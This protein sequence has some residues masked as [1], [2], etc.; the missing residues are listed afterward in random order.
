MRHPSSRPRLA[1]CGL[2]LALL[3][4]C[5]GGDT[6]APA[7]EP[8]SCTVA[9]QQRWLGEYMDGWYF[10]YRLS[11]RPDPARYA[12]VGGYFDALL[13]TGTSA[14]FPADRWSNFE[15]TESFNR[16]FGEGQN[17]GYGVSVAG[18]EVAGDPTAPLFVRHVDPLSPAAT[19]GVQRGDEVL[20]IDGRS[21]AEL[22]A[23]DDYAQLSPASAGQSITLRL[24]RGGLDRTV[25]VVA[26][27]YALSPVTGTAVVDSPLGRRLGYVAVKDMIGQ[28]LAPLDAAFASFRSAGVQD[29][30][31]DL[32]YNGGGLVS[33]G[34]TL[35]SYVAGAQGDGLNYATLLYN[36]KRAAAYNTSFRFSLPGNALGL[37]RAFVLAGPRTCSAS[38]QVI[39]GL[40]GA[41]V[42]VVAIGDTTC[43]KPVG[44]LPSSACG[45]TYSVVNFESVNHRNEGRYFDGFDATCPVSENF[46]T[47]QG[48]SSDPL[49]DAARRYADTGR[50]PLTPLSQA[51]QARRAGAAT[52]AAPRL[53]RA[54]AGE[55]Q[56]MIPR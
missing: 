47:A 18:L 3:A 12:T 56:G 4:A 21:A 48:G 1:L 22:I 10:W 42:Q 45:Q 6:G 38:E 33:T 37:R 9:D 17:L 20:A 19:L 51:G 7:D 36:D 44:F 41:G 40:R 15:S 11:P 50:C 25:T 23:A 39:N 31:L 26:A 32:R 35:A 53:R 46:G 14:D 16:F 52:A 28:A 54:E 55:R 5:G 49:L 27:V 30:V 24:R 8:G 34:A 29:V 13:Y 43:G 2:A